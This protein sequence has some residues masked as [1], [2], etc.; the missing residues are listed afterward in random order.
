MYKYSVF[1]FYMYRSCTRILTVYSQLTE[2]YLHFRRKKMAELGNSSNLY[3][4][5]CKQLYEKNIFRT[6][7]EKK[8]MLI[9]F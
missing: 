6:H 7:F 9:V 2:M 1:I 3:L 4:F 8:C 5:F